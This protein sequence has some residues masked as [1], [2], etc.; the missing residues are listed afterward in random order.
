VRNAASTRPTALFP[1]LL[2][3]GE[4]EQLPPRLAQYRPVDV[5]AQV[6]DAGSFT[7]HTLV[8][9]VALGGVFEVKLGPFRPV[10]AQGS[11]TVP[12]TGPVSS[13]SVS[14]TRYGRFSA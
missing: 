1:D 12:L 10:Q 7:D 13:P 9:D 8:H 11:T 2:D 14:G 3:P 4:E 6:V 5:C